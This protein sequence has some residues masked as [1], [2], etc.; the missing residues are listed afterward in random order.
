MS[1]WMRV[2]STS[3]KERER[4]QFRFLV[5][6]LFLSLPFLCLSFWLLVLTFMPNLK[7][8]LLKFSE[9]YSYSYFSYTLTHTH[10]QRHSYDIWIDCDWSL[11][12]MQLVTS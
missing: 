7:R 9:S 11:K 5:F 6:C 10:T 12:M 3:E 8:S 4:E 1:H 2:Q